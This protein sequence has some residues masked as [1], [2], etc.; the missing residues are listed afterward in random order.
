M[1]DSERAG[2]ERSAACGAAFQCRAGRS[3]CAVH[4]VERLLNHRSG[5]IRGVA[6][7]YNRFDYW[8]EREAA[9]QMWGRYVAS[10]VSSEERSNVVVLRGTS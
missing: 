4:V 10:L 9:A 7:I 2:Q 3:Q 1:D 5:M 6:A 8:S